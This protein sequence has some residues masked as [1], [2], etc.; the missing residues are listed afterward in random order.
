MNIVMFCY[1]NLLL[2]VLQDCIDSV[3][4]MLQDCIV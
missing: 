2:H 4:H 3:T 1:D